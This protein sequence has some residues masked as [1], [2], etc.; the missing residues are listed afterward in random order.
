M[1]DETK[2]YPPIIKFEPNIPVT[3]KLKYSSGKECTSEFGKSF[4]WGTDEVDGK[5]SFFA[6]EA[7]NHKIVTLGAGEFDK[8]TI[9]KKTGDNKTWF[10]VE[11]A[12]V[13]VVSGGGSEEAA[14]IPTPEPTVAPTVAPPSDLGGKFKAMHSAC[15]TNPE[16]TVKLWQVFMAETSVSDEDLP[17]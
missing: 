2:T 7:L 13:P 8:I 9:C 3:V 17:F 1:M 11:M 12:D 6:T 10:E 14:P 5:Q 4:L 15:K 16:L